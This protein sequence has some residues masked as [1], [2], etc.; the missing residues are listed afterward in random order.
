[1][2]EI[3]K[4]FTLIDFTGIFA[5]GA[6]MTLAVNF[7]VLDLTAPFDSF[8]GENEVMLALYFLTLSYLVG[9]ALHQLGAWLEHRLKLYLGHKT[10]HNSQE[11]QD[12]Y[13]R[14]FHT[15]IPENLKE[16]WARILHYIQ[17]NSRPDRVILF[18][19]FYTMSRTTMVTLIC[20]I[21]LIIYYCLGHSV[22]ISQLTV[23]LALAYILMIGLFGSRWVRFEK[24]FVEEVYLLFSF[25]NLD[26]KEPTKH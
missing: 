19:S 14:C 9:S 10:W 3:L 12:A 17:R 13:V 15:K 18:N 2:D 21:P 20:L 11:I 26:T 22:Q 7:C 5:P 8:F 6:I 4:R 24:K 25:Q 23:S 16:A 1:M